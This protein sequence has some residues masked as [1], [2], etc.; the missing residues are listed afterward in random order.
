MAKPRRKVSAKRRA[1][2]TKNPK[3]R[4]RSGRTHRPARRS[5]NP[6]G[7]PPARL[8]K[9]GFGVFIGAS[10]TK[11]LPQF[12]PATLTATPLMAIF[13]SAVTAGLLAWGANL[14]KFTRG[15]FAEGVLWGGVAQVV[16]VAWNAFVP[17]PF[18]SYATLGDF[19]PGE[20]PLP[21]GPVRYALSPAADM[22]PNGQQMNVGAYAPAW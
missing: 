15:D 16:N 22:T 10:T 4:R 12:Y 1:G 20:Y 7:Q 14:V 5:G 21:Q 6:F 2:Y 19:V 3:S 9:V 17:Q 18:A 13:S 8:M 11:K